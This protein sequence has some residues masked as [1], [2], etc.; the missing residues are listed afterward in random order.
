MKVAQ[1]INVEGRHMTTA[2]Q[3]IG[4]ESAAS[5]DVYRSLRHDIIANNLKPDQRLRF[6]ALK[7]AYQAG[8]GTLREALSH[9]VSDGLVRTE[10]G[11]GFRVAPV[12]V[13][14]LM[15]VTEWRIEFEVRAVTASIQKGDD[16]WEAEIVTAYHLL[17]K[18]GLPDHDAPAEL[19]L[20]YSQKHERFHNALAASCGSPWL[21]Y[22]R[23]ALSAQ[24]QRYQ[25]LAVIRTEPRAHRGDDEHRAIMDAVLG[26]DRKLAS[27][28]I[29]THIRHTADI[30]AKELADFEATV[31]EA[32]PRA[33]KR[34]AGKRPSKKAKSEG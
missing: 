15:D 33:G 16:A 11:R 27:K 32:S 9:L 22:F 6:D 1:N 13:T 26:R 34:K 14:D 25:G 7:Q 5:F 12:S 20:A 21:L 8:V 17:S 3:D 30:V 19:W 31:P 28:L 10:V 4:Q 29:E 23:S 24:A 18:A 2:P